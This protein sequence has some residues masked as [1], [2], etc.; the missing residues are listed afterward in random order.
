MSANGRHKSEWDWMSAE[1]DYTINNN[2][3]LDELND[4]VDNII[5]QLQDRPQTIEAA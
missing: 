4:N 2:G 5:R 3:T 1:F